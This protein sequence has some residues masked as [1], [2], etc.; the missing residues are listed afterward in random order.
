MKRFYLLSLLLPLILIS[1]GPDDVIDRTTEL[2]RQGNIHELAKNF[3]SSVDLTIMGQEDVYPASEAE[4]VL[5]DFFKKNICKSAT[6]LHRITSNANY[7][8]AVLTILSGNNTFRVAF[9]LKSAKGGYE[10]TELR[11]EAE[12]TK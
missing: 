8:Y 2:I 11:I 4:T 7:R 9:N 3:S 12:K 1:A 5:A 6:V 10:L